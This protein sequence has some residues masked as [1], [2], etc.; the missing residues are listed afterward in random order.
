MSIGENKISDSQKSV[1]TC[2]VVDQI[3]INIQN[4][5]TWITFDIF[6]NAKTVKNASTLRKTPFTEG[7][8]A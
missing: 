5:L 8:S 6:K 4:G 3:Q 2:L 1:I 7:V